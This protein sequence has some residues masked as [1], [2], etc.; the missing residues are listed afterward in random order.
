M[1]QGPDTFDEVESAEDRPAGWVNAIAA[2]LLSRKILTLQDRNAQTGRRA[3]RRATRA[4]WSAADDRDIEHSSQSWKAECASRIG[5]L[6]SPRG[7]KRR[8]QIAAP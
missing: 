2:N 8:L 3:K 4:G 7:R 6:Q 5:D 1:R